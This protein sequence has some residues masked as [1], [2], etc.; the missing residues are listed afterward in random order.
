ML[1]CVWVV[2]LTAKVKREFIGQ[3]SDFLFSD[4]VLSVV[5][6]SSLA[7]C[8]A[9]LDFLVIFCTICNPFDCFQKYP[10]EPLDKIPA[11]HAEFELAGKNCIG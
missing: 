5:Y 11:L 7:N 4:R 2:F 9:S 10:T 1:D 3:R 8:V 6:E